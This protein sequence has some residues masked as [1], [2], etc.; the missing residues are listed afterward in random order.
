M[1]ANGNVRCLDDAIKVQELGC[2][3]LCCLGAVVLRTERWYGCQR[4]CV[5]SCS[6]PVVVVVV[7]VVVVR[8]CFVGTLTVPLCLVL[9]YVVCSCGT[10]CLEYTKCDAVMSAQGILKN[11]AIFSEKPTNNFDIGAW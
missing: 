7:V 2:S 3:V 8:V 11:P 5:C 4:V 10:Q 6:H 1:I 9:L